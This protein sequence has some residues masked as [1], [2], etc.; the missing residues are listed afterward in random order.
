MT[1]H[2]YK[3]NAYYMIYLIKCVLH[4]KVPAK[5]KV[6][7]IDLTQLYEVAKSH[8]LTAITAYALESAG[9]YDESFEEE[10]NK[11][12]RKNILLDVERGKVFAEFEKACIWYTPLKGI[13]LKDL[14]PKIGMR[15]M[16]DNDI[17]F[18]PSKA[19]VVK[20]I[21]ERLGYITSDFGGRNHDV[22]FKPPVCNFEMHNALFE[23]WRFNNLFEYYRNTKEKL[24]QDDNGH[25]SYQ[26]T[27]ED[28]YIYT[29]AHEFKHYNL[30]GTG[31]RSLID[32]YV[33]LKQYN[34]LLDMDYIDYELSKMQLFEYELDS[35]ELA[36]HLFEFKDLNDNEKKILDYYIFS[37]TYGNIENTVNN[38][39]KKLG[40]GNVARVK[41]L[42]DRFLVPIRESNPKYQIYK[43]EYPL[44]Y[45]YKL[46]LPLLPFYRLF[47][48]LHKNRKGI[49]TEIKTLIKL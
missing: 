44:F 48:S 12:I 24:L 42:F 14:Y 20:D 49:F 19:D 16:A 6:D 30:G 33:Y 2:D 40:G 13:V 28:F 15:Q 7:K 41:Y 37:G 5:E 46:I 32:K 45:K 22:Y 39:L 47:R 1:K 9:I 31:L 29:T 25:Y 8:T 3:L 11:A 10:K 23:Q 43:S 36:L 34:S 18:D 27:K 38:E 35:R 17:L 26:F 21:M 4:N